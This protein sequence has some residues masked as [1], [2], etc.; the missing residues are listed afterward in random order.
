[1]R[2]F[3]TAILVAFFTLFGSLL[4][5][6]TPFAKEKVKGYLVKEASKRGL[7]LQIE[8]IQGRLPFEWTLSDVS[9]S[10]TNHQPNLTFDSLKLRLSIFPLRK[11]HIE[12]TYC[13][14][15]GG[16]YGEIPFNAKATFWIDLQQ[17]KSIKLTHFLAEGDGLHLQMEGKLSPDLALEKGNL[18]FYLSDVGIFPLIPGIGSVMGTAELSKTNAQLQC[19]TQDLILGDI[20]FENGKFFVEASKTLDKWNGTGSL[21]GGPIDLPLISEFSFLFNP[22][23]RWVSIEDFHLWGEEIDFYG[24]FDLDPK[25]GCMEGTLLAQCLDLKV[26]RPFFPETYLKGRVGGKLI[27]KSFASFQDLLCQ[28]ELEEFGIYEMNSKA[29]TL[30]CNLYDL[31][32]NIQGECSIEG[33]HIVLP[34]AEFVSVQLTSNLEPTFSPFSFIAEGSWKAPLHIEG[35][36]EW[37]QRDKGIFLNMDTLEG[38]A[39]KKAFSLCEPFSLEWNLNQCKMSNFSLD[40]GQGHLFSRIDLTPTSSLIKIKGEAFPLALLSL[41]QK[42]FSLDGTSSFDIDLVAWENHLQGSCNLSL[43]R[44]YIHSE[45]GAQSLASKG[46]LQMHLSGDRAQIHTEVKA[47]GG[48]FLQAF[49]SVPIQYSHYPLKIGIALDKPLSGE[50]L[51]EG[52]LEDLFQFINIGAHR[53]EGW[54]SSHLFLS[55]TAKTPHLQGTLELQDGRYENE[56]TGTELQEVFATAEANGACFK[57]T[58]LFAKDKGGGTAEAKGSFLLSKKN[59]F[60]FTLNATLN[61]LSAISFDTISGTFD[62]NLTITGDRF[63]STAK[64]NLKVAKATFRIP[65][66]LPA[67]L[68][69]LP[70]TFINPPEKLV[71]KKLSPPTVSPMLLDLDL[72]VPGNAYVE[73]KGLQSEL[74]GKLHLS[75][76]Y[77]DIA[78]EGKLQLVKGE[79]IFSGKVFNLSQGEMI[80][81]ASPTPSAYISLSGTCDLPDVNVT[82]LLRGPLSGP[83][84]TFQSSPQL[85]VSSLLAQILFNKDFSEVSAVQ[86][87][88][89]AQT[90]LSLSG[91]SAPDI[92]E[93]VRKT[94]GMDRLTLITSENDPGK[95]SLQIGKYLMR[96][97]L[98]TVSQG[99]ESRKASV[100]V[101]LKKGI[102]LQAEVNED[103]QGKFSLKWHHHY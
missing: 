39:C 60:P 69:E 2:A 5:L 103:Q 27:F 33:Q 80:F 70:I 73:G 93:R 25:I 79:Y 63:G 50:L 59:H 34:D 82:A 20:P 56:Y 31:F 37:Q 67:V 48:Q 41:P 13:K 16:K 24:K 100:E 10:F 6:Q 65:D 94:L 66:E 53:I 78:A 28:L 12:C 96:G 54:L 98:L 102:H 74:Q 101:E 38:F 14:V 71:R 75:G 7:Q 62:G 19:Q 9:C 45:D 15:S 58:N 46:S 99:A 64:G 95:I 21:T 17:K 83:K 84:L 85:P 32:G 68:P 47:Q 4:F 55:K 36:G 72:E 92:L 90:V 88:Q 76:T 42:N 91:G 49:A 89:V 18:T 3:V 57:I 77:I 23:D 87:L 97:V 61:Q 26:L 86:A 40:I 30:E 81:T 11:K 43:K 44:A 52:R 29:L 51:A 8:K 22:K 1:M 35:S